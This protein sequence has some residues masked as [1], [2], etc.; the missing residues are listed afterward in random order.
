[1]IGTGEHPE[2]G[3]GVRRQRDESAASSAGITSE[4]SA[5]GSRGMERTGRQAPTT[6]EP[7]GSAVA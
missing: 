3:E 7:E 5:A 6:R 1:M 4:P 2:H